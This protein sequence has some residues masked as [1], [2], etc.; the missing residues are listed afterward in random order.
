MLRQSRDIDAYLTAVG[1]HNPRLLSGPE[2][3]DDASEA[4]G[5]GKPV[6]QNIL[7]AVAACI[8]KTGHW[9]AG[10]G[11]WLRDR[12]RYV[13]CTLLYTRTCPSP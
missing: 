12:V 13:H 8:D 3:G 5:E 10:L 1:I 6:L 9:L 7:E 11:G 2:P 4:E